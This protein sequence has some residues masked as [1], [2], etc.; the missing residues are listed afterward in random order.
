MLAGH[1]QSSNADIWIRLAD[2][3]LQE[4]KISAAVSCYNKAIKAEP[5]NIDLHLKRLTLVQE[6][7]IFSGRITITKL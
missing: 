7:G 2:V 1:L 4:N 5:K 6:K 3:E